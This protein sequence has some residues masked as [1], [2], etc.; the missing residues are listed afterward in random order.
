MCILDDGTLFIRI[1][2]LWKQQCNIQSNDDVSLLLTFQVWMTEQRRGGWVESSY[3]REKCPARRKWVH[4]P[5][6][7]RGGILQRLI[8]PDIGFNCSFSLLYHI[9]SLSSFPWFKETGK[10]LESDVDYRTIYFSAIV[11]RLQWTDV[12]KEH[13]SFEGCG[14]LEENRLRGKW[15]LKIANCVYSFNRKWL[16]VSAKNHTGPE[17]DSGKKTA[18]AWKGFCALPPWHMAQ[19]GMLSGICKTLQYASFSQEVTGVMCTISLCLVCCW[20]DI[21]IYQWKLSFR[22]SQT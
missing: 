11:G 9:R 16:M 14:G 12:K 7:G 15:G 2:W 6:W 3:C 4:K 20:F 22:L 10:P 5:L 17:S 1:W 21:F 8:A 13:S 19:C 18:E